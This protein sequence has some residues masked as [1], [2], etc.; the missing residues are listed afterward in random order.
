ME[1]NTV[2]SDIE[3]IFM[4]LTK[5]EKAVKILLEAYAESNNTD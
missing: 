5:L 4:R 3:E 2:K 1:L